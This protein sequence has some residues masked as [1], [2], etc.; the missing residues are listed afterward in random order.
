MG[1]ALTDS[2]R[3]PEGLKLLEQALPV[4][5]RLA[6]DHPDVAAFQNT[7]GHVQNLIGTLRF[8]LG[9]PAEAMESFRQSSPSTSGWCATTPPSPST[10]RVSLVPST[11]SA[12]S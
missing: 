12:G 1:K 11:V 10:S 3:V 9:R 5:E 7:L 2:G 8:D 4:Q 6:R